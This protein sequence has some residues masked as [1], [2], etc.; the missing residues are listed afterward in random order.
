MEFS[1]LSGEPKSETTDEA[2]TPFVR[3]VFWLAAAAMSN[4]ADCHLPPQGIRLR[5]SVPRAKGKGGPRPPVFCAFA[6]TKSRYRQA[7]TG[8]EFQ[9]SRAYCS[10][11]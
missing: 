9:Y 1:L 11:R 7:R 3:R 5:V 2:H 8:T 6:R 10:C 4:S